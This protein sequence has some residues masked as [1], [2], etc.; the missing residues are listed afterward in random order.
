MSALRDLIFDAIRQADKKL[1]ALCVTANLFGILLIYSATRYRPAFHSF[2]IKQGIAMVIGI[3][4]YFA[5]SQLNLDVLRKKWRWVMVFCTLLILLLKTPFGKDVNGNRAWLHFPGFPF[6]LQPA[7]IDKIFFAVILSHLILY[8]KRNR[9]LNDLSSIVMMGGLLVYFIGLLFV[10]SGDAGSC[11]IYVVIFIFM[12]WAA[13]VSKLW[14]ALGISAVGAGGYVAW[15]KLLPADHYWRKRIMVCFDHDLDPLGMGFQQSKS[16]MA[17]QSGGL[18]GQG[19]LKG[20]LTQASL[21][22]RLPERQTD[23]IFASCC[24]EWGMIGAGFVILILMAIIARCLYIGLTAPDSFSSL[25]CIGYAGM[26]I[27]QIWLNLGMCLYVMPVIGVTLPFFSYGGS[28]IMTNYVIMGIISGIH[29]RNEPDWLK[30]SNTPEHTQPQRKSV[31]YT[32]DMRHH[33]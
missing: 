6:N 23:F 13:G 24:E 29:N 14:F 20:I 15:T 19:F 21:P 12:L 3:V 31:L 27:A 30:N 7:E 22:S 8:I 16:L 2:P 17:I 26:F 28:S 25:I 33:R 18:T 4:G 11:L 1:L 9:R 32:P 5:V 10:I